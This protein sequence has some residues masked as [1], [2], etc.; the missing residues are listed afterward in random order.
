MGGAVG[1]YPVE[2][3]LV[4]LADL[5]EIEAVKRDKSRNWQRLEGTV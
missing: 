5:V 1:R 3:K 2:V 4:G